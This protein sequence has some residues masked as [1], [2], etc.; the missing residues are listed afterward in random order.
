MA[1]PTTIRVPEDLLEEIDRFVKELNLDRATYMREVLRKGFSLDKQE[2]LLR[3]YAR[4]ELSMMEVCQKLGMDPWELL[5][6]LKVQ[7][8]NLNVELEH[9]L[10]SADLTEGH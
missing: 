3:D 5:S 4:G 1:K 10:D 9:W 7:N 8:L 2:R 6:T